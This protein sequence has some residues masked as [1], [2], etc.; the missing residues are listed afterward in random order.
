MT[1]KGK[2]LQHE[3]LKSWQS[4]PRCGRI[5][6]PRSAAFSALRRADFP[7]R[8]ARRGKNRGKRYLQ[9]NRKSLAT[10]EI[11]RL[12]LCQAAS[13]RIFSPWK[14]CTATACKFPTKNT[15]N[16]FEVLLTQFEPPSEFNTSITRPAFETHPAA[17]LASVLPLS[18]DR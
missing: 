9:G 2:G 14:P 17:V 5:Y 12:L 4:P 10:L 13:I 8:R 11:A 1:N 3:L 16:F 18:A 6:A 7:H 15:C